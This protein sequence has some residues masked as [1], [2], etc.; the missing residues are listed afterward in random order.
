M[1]LKDA[2]ERIS[3]RFD[4][5]Y[6][7]KEKEFLTQSLLRGLLAER[8]IQLMKTHSLAAEIGASSYVEI[9]EQCV[10]YLG[11]NK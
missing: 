5:D 8:V 2:I 1:F 7:W 3:R 4:R 6:G 9:F 10:A 11:L